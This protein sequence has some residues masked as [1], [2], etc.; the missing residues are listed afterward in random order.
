ME[1]T[2]QRKVWKVVNPLLDK[3]NQSRFST[4]SFVGKGLGIDVFLKL[5]DNDF[6]L[7]LSIQSDSLFIGN[8]SVIQGLGEKGKLVEEELVFDKQELSDY[9]HKSRMG[10]FRRKVVSRREL[11]GEGLISQ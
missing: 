5:K 11:R 9:N 2:F 8:Y 10:F 3:L 6:I 7:Y 1:S 4:D